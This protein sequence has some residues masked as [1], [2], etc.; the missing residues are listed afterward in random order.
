MPS[1]STRISQLKPSPT[2][3]LNAKA[4]ALKAEGHDVLN[5][6]V[7]EPDFSCPPETIEVATQALQDGLTKY[8]QAGG[9][10]ELRTAISNKL[11]RENDLSFPVDQIVC[12]IGAKE[13]LFHIMLATLNEGDEVIINAPCWVS[14]E[15]QIKAAGAKP[16]FIP[17]TDY[18]N[19][20]IISAEVIEKYATDKT[21]AFILCSPNNPAGYSLSLDELVSLG[22][23]LKQKDWWIISDEIYEY[24]SFENPH[25]SLLKVCPEL[26][27]R[28]IHVNGIAKGYAMTGW[29]VGYTAAPVEVAKLVKSLQSHSSTC[30]PPFIEKA[31]TWAINQGPSIMKEKI[32]SLEARRQLAIEHLNKLNGVSYIKPQGAFYIFVDIR[33]ALANANGYES[34]ESLKFAQYLL[35][36]QYMAVV[37]GEAFQSP[38]F[39]RFSYAASES[40]IKEGIARLGQALDSIQG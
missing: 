6:A 22:E 36:S 38:G 3:A 2:V 26:E 7:G 5:F 15:E 40:W 28:Y 9:N 21:K 35:E 4:K 16:V 29:R 10:L 18:E 27:G 25:T 14:Y 20:S 31:A 39:L 23:Y 34:T 11:K 12:G 30:I 37:P 13:I 19:S 8:S 24:M 33:K 1:V 32:D 17:L